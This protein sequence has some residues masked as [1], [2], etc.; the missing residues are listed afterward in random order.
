MSR[1]KKIFHEEYAELDNPTD[2][3]VYDLYSKHYNIAPVEWAENIEYP[4]L[5][6]DYGLPIDWTYQSTDFFNSQLAD[7]LLATL[8]DEASLVKSVEVEEDNLAMI[9]V[10]LSAKGIEIVGGWMTFD[11]EDR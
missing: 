1:D 11:L 5:A 7:H 9:Q 6:G 10:F 8:G 4:P 2:Q 3:E